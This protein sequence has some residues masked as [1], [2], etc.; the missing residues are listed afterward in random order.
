MFITM[1]AL[2]TAF[3]SLVFAYYFFW[4]IHDDFPPDP[5]V[6]PGAFWP[7]VG[8]GL[9][10]AAWAL[11]LLARRFN[12]SDR[13]AAFQ[14]CAGLAILM[15]AAGAAALLAG[16]YVTNMDPEQH[17]YQA[18]VWLLLIWCAAHAALGILMNAYCM[19]RRLAGRMTAEYDM[20]ISNVALYWHFALLMTLVTVATVAGF[21][22]V[23]Q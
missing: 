5:S 21:P 16:P 3:V 12:R 10:V 20:D 4:T 6:G 15:S 7:L 13:G 19:G 11:T 9:I 23:T 22:L 2:T 8:G 18:T 14:L 17:V 1:L